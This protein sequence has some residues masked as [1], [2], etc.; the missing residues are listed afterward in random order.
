MNI[1]PQIVFEILEFKKPCNL[2]GGE[3][4][5][6]WPEN[7]T[8]PKH[9][10]HKIIR[11]IMRHLKEKIILPPLK[12]KI[13]CFWSEFALFIQL[14]RQQIQFPEIRLC[15]LLVYKAKCPNEKNRKIH[16]VD[17]EKNVFKDGHT[18][19]YGWENRTDF[20]GPLLQRWRFDLMFFRN[21]KIK[22]S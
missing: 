13:F 8:F 15:H 20:I 6:L 2:I 1:V 7:Q 9:S 21:W 14:S 18:E 16:Q 5:G 3:H 17:P 22:F 12:S 19:R 4:F 11:P 10:F